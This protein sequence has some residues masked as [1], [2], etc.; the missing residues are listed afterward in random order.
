MCT[1]EDCGGCRMS[2]KC[3]R[4]SWWFKNQTHVFVDKSLTC[5]YLIRKR[6][7]FIIY[8]SQK[9][10]KLQNEWRLRI[11]GQAYIFIACQREATLKDVASEAITFKPYYKGVL[12]PDS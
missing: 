3:L 10:M 5:I 4:D 11:D 12:I 2:K 8:S 9:I 6:E 1:T 7:N